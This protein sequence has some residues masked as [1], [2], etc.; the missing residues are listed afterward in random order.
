MTRQ[1]EKR[2]PYCSVIGQLKASLGIIRTC[3]DMAESLCVLNESCIQCA[4]GVNGE[5]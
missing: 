1:L 4:A 3:S 5:Q 2:A